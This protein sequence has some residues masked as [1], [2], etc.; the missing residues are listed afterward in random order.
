MNNNDLDNREAL[1]M[2]FINARNKEQRAHD[3]LDKLNNS[4][5]VRCRI[6]KD[7]KQKCPGV[8]IDRILGKIYKD[9]L[10]FEEPSHNMSDDDADDEIK[11]FIAQRTNGKNSEYYVREALKKNSNNKLLNK[12]LTES[13][14]LCKEYYSETAKDIATIDIKSL[15]YNPNDHMDEISDTL[16]NLDAEGLSELIANNVKQALDAEAE[17]ANRE[18]EYNKSVEDSLTNDTSVTDTE[19]MESALHKMRP[20]NFPKVYQPSLMESVLIHMANSH[21]NSSKEEIFAEATKEYTKL[22][23]VKALKLENFNL[24]STRA[25]ANSYLK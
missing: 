3:S 4:F 17:R 10:P 2:D 18:A 15:M 1:V 11:N 25:L 22:S 24:L 16:D 13:Q 20:L 23:L 19:A 14:R 5:D 12:I 21:P 6:A 7:E 8:I 9:A